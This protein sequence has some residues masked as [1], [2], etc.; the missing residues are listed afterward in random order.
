MP[1]NLLSRAG[2]LLNVRISDRLAAVEESISEACRR[3][4]R[5]RS[6]IILVAVS[7][8]QPAIP[9]SEAVAAGVR[10]LGES[11]VQ[12]AAGKK[13]GVSGSPQWHLVGHLQSNKARKAA[14]IFDW[15]HS[16]DSEKTARRVSEQAA[17]L[18]R[19]LR[20]LIQVNLGDESQKGGVSGDEISRLA[21]EIIEMPSI[22][23]VGLMTIPPIGTAEEARRWFARMR[24]LR[25]L[26]TPIAGKEAT[27]LS[28]GMSDDYEEA[29][30]EGATIIRVGRA[31]FGERE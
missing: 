20:V 31:I 19:N 21:E 9:A 15:I 10:H 30:E 6:E 14:E 4:G 17:R 24:G 23:L 2:G 27:H 11:R 22:E 18:G 28:M 26:L 25:E 12:E 3:S 5:N 16:I 29:I 8:T 1:E 13:D 7:K